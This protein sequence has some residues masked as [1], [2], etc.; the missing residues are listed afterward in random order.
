MLVAST[1]IGECISLGQFLL[2]VQ[3]APRSK[4]LCLSH[5]THLLDG[6]DHLPAYIGV[7]SFIRN[8]GVIQA[9]GPQDQL[10]IGMEVYGTNDG[11]IGA[12][13]V[14]DVLSFQLRKGGGPTVVFSIAV[15][16]LEDTKMVW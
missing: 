9:P 4:K 6:I 14:D 7:K 5:V 12:E 1:S 2:S 11:G 13:V 3:H 15:L 16:F 10:P 8:C